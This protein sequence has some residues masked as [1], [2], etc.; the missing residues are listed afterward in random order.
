M[1]ETGAR[2][3]AFTPTRPLLLLTDFSPEAKGGGAVILQSLLSAEDRER[4]VWVTL[5]P[6]KSSSDDR[7]VSLASAG[8]R[9]LFRDAT[10]RV[11]A[12]RRA[13]REV[14][15]THGADAAWVVAHGASVR[16]APALI[17]TGLPVHI[18]VHD[19]P[20]WAYALLT[21]RYLALAPLLARDLSR[22][23]R[24]AR[25]VDV[26]SSGMAQRYLRQHRVESTIVHRGLSGPV[27]PAPVYDSNDGLSVGVLGSTYGL[28]ELEV[29]ASALALVAQQQVPTRLT[30]IGGVQKPLVRRICPPEVVLELPGHLDEREGIAMLRRSFLQ[31]LCYPFGRRGKVLRTTSFPT[32]LSTYVMAARPLL[33]HTPVDSSVAGLGFLSPYGTLWSSLDAQEGADLMSA[34]WF[35][36]HASQSF[37]VAA[38]RQ[39]EQHY[40]L[41]ANRSALLGVLNALVATD[42]P[43]R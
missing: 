16:I 33:L 12:L 23:L 4:I 1:N 22:S 43:A 25:S 9:S 13:T 19:D 26:V 27:Q 34:L 21:R 28:R 2:L 30:V 3:T 17:A 24:S 35:G 42:P 20:A 11:G 7:V 8:R 10:T 37:H 18:T 38:E 39:R 32:K 31:Y 14:M 29:L 15:L 41:L 5:S 6:I 36:G 40:D